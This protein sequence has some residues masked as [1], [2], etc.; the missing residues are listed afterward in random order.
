VT[1][2]SERKVNTAQ[3][4]KESLKATCLP[5]IYSYAL[6]TRVIRVTV[7]IDHAYHR[8][9]NAGFQCKIDVRNAFG[10]LY[11]SCLY[12]KQISY[13]LKADSHIPCRSHAV[14]MP[15]PCRSHAVL[16]PF[17]CY[18]PAVPLPCRYSTALDCVFPI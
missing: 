13:S 8:H 1:Y 17:P 4:F 14:P 11:V 18:S 9:T 6:L 10:K 7:Y 16:L 3:Y 2:E 12:H 15:F 5:N